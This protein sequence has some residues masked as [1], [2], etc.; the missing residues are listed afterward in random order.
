MKS[1]RG[2]GVNWGATGDRVRRF[3]RVEKNVPLIGPILDTG[4][5]LPGEDNRLGE[6]WRSLGQKPQSR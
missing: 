6:A 2:R 5:H 3:R 4:R 1:N